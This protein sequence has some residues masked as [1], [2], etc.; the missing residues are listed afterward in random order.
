MYF[1]LSLITMA[2]AFGFMFGILTLPSASEIF[3]EGLHVAVLAVVAVTFVVSGLVQPLF[4]THPLCLAVCNSLSVIGEE[5]YRT[6][7]QSRQAVPGRGEGLADT[8]H[9]D[10]I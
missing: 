8:L 5:D 6:I 10:A 9:V 3:A 1:V 2:L 4:F 7:A